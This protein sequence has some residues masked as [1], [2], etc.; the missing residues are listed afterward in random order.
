MLLSEGDALKQVKPMP[1]FNYQEM[2]FK[3]VNISTDGI[4]TFESPSLGRGIMDYS[5]F[6]QY[7]EK[8]DESKNAEE[9]LYPPKRVWSEWKDAD[10]LGYEMYQYK[11]NGKRLVARFVFGGM[12]A[13]T[14]CHPSDTFDIAKG[15]KLAVARIRCKSAAKEVA[16]IKASM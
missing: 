6:A 8:W 15:L 1:Q 5:T 9:S 3:V 2:L 16:A 7:F 13:S 4:I 14:S 11:E 10:E 12:Q